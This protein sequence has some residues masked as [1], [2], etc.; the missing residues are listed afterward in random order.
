MTPAVTMT[1]AANHEIRLSRREL[2]GPVAMALSDEAERWGRWNM[3][4][5]APD[6]PPL[7]FPAPRFWS[8]QPAR[9]VVAL[10]AGRRTRKRAAFFCALI[11]P[12][13]A[14]HNAQADRHFLDPHHRCR[15]DRH[16]PSLRVRLLRNPGLQGAQGRRL[17]DR[18]GEFQPG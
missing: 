9:G 15:P 6:F 8:K 2:S 4:V 7:P 1:A 10:C 11:V 12:D 16:R 17:S 3:R 13:I 14:E 18:A 5:H